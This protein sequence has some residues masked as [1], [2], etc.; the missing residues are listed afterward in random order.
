MISEAGGVVLIV[1]AG[2]KSP[3]QLL[4]PEISTPA[5]VATIISLKLRVEDVR[6]T[7]VIATC[8]ET[9]VDDT[10]EVWPSEDTITPLKTS[11]AE[12]VDR[13]VQ[14]VASDAVLGIT[15]VL[16]IDSSMVSWKL[17]GYCAIQEEIELDSAGSSMA[18]IEHAPPAVVAVLVSVPLQVVMVVHVLEQVS[19]AHDAESVI[20]EHR[21]EQL[22][23]GDAEQ[24]LEEELDEPSEELAVVAEGDGVPVTVFGSSSP[25]NDGGPVGC[26]AGICID[27]YE[28]MFGNLKCSQVDLTPTLAMT[29]PLD[30]RAVQTSI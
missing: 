23:I 12:S 17:K 10:Q 20:V 24:E 3:V 7:G 1:V 13:L 4:E 25:S 5:Q 26:T 2:T 19:E 6:V 14:V 28:A 29:L 21:L 15:V 16:R 18:L 9:C 8:V 22:V 11:P 27:K 30:D